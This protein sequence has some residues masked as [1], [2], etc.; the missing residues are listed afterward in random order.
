MARSVWKSYISVWSLWPNRDTPTLDL[1][2]NQ[3]MLLVSHLQT[4][5]S[6]HITS[7]QTVR[8]PGKQHNPFY[9]IYLFI[10]WAV[11]GSSASCLCCVNLHSQPVMMIQLGEPIS[12]RGDQSSRSTQLSTFCFVLDFFS[13]LQASA[14]VHWTAVIQSQS[15]AAWEAWNAFWTSARE[16]FN[17]PVVTVFVK[18][19]ASITHHDMY[20]TRLWCHHDVIRVI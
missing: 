10:C 19:P 8:T 4:C 16:F 20:Y 1:T 3:G 6:W 18:N 9:F 13:L 12:F 17:K 7:C 2:S 14:S 15:G 5:K 11:I